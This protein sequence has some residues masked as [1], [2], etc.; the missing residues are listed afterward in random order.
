MNLI[1][2]WIKRRVKQA[3]REREGGKVDSFFRLI[4]DYYGWLRVVQVCRFLSYRQVEG[5][6]WMF[7]EHLDLFKR[8]RTANYTAR[9]KSSKGE[10]GY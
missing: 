6:L 7:K 2:I 3:E 10:G 1:F 9:T 5:F 8:S 4:N